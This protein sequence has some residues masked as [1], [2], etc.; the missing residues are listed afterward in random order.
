[1]YIEQA[2]QPAALRQTSA[3]RIAETKQR[4]TTAS[5]IGG[6]AQ[7]SFSDAS[8]VEISDMGK[9]LQKN[10]KKEREKGACQKEVYGKEVAARER[11]EKYQQIDELE[12]KLESQQYS[13]E[14]KAKIQEQINKLKEDLKTPQEKLNDKIASLKEQQAKTTDPKAIAEY[15][16]MIKECEAQK[17]D[18]YARDHAIELGA[19]QEEADNAV[20]EMKEN[21]MNPEEET[22]GS[23]ELELATPLQ[24]IQIDEIIA[25]D[26]ENEEDKHGETD[27]T[28]EDAD[29]KKAADSDTNG[30]ENG[31]E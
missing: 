15:Q 13:E 27:K 12:E 28:A 21:R 18:L 7:P 14:D 22:A 11:Q 6:A 17:K 26:E 16:C 29:T 20:K 2:A 25:A 9:Q 5:K 24:D 30:L 31:S 19:L 10:A 1:M 4:P 3:S 23:K 8:S